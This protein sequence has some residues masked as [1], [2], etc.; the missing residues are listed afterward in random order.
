M[1][2]RF[3]F[4]FS[5]VR[6]H[7]GSQASDSARAVEAIAYTVG[8]DVV[9][10]SGTFSPNTIEGRKLLAH[11]LTH[12]IQQENLPS[13]GVGDISSRDTSSIDSRTLRRKQA[14][15]TQPDPLAKA[16]KGDDDDV[17]DLTKDSSWNAID[18]TPAQALC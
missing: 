13:V 8:H 10:G 16:L 11:E 6:V 9:F 18:L 15:G 7:T 1:E 2:S 3:G 4:D 5:S 14:P 17:R 12:I